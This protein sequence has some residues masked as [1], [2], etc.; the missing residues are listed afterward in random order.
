MSGDAIAAVAADSEAIA[1]E[2]IGLIDVDYEELPY[3]DDPVEA[4]KPSA[5]LIHEDRNKYK[6]TPKL[7]EGMS[8]A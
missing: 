3:V 6:N 1:D 8:G 5:P 7:P 4:L 2:A